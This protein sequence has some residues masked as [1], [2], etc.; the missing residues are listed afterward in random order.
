MS[1]AR[2]FFRLGVVAICLIIALISASIGLGKVLPDNGQ[3]IYDAL[4]NQNYDIFV[5]DIGR[6]IRYNLTHNT[7]LDTQAAWSP[8]GRYIAFRSRRDQQQWL[9]IMDADGG[10]VRPLTNDPTISQYNPVWSPD[11]IYIFY[12]SR[13][14]ANAPIFRVRADG[15]DVQPFDELAFERLFEQRFD[16]NRFMVMLYK[17]GNWGISTYGSNRVN[18]R[19]LTNNNIFFRELPS[20]SFDDQQIAF[21]SLEKTKSE[22]YVMNADGSNFRQITDDSIRK[23]NLSWRP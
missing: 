11:G 8:D 18:R 17:N 1:A 4:V 16:P 2:W 12:R 9:Y 19:Q 5:L 7:A 6:Y 14:S 15:S 10:N 22:V 13:P 3:L 23:S 21:I 20:W